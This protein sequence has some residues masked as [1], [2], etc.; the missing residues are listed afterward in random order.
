MS[1]FT[2]EGSHVMK[3]KFIGEGSYGCLYYPGVDCNGKKNKKK[4]ITKIQ[5]I[6]F[7]SKNEIIIGKLIKKINNF[8]KYYAPITKFCIISFNKLNNSN[9]ELDKCEV[10]FDD[11]FY[12]N[13]QNNKLI[14]TKYFLTYIKYINNKTLKNFF[15]DIENPSIFF[16]NYLSCFLWLLNSLIILNK[17]N[18]IHNDL[19]Y[20][21]ILYNLKIKYPMI[22]DFGLSYDLK[23]LYKL[24]KNID[25]KYIK[26]FFFD[27]RSDSYNHN[28]EKRFISFIVYN[29]HDYFYSNVESNFEKNKLTKKIIKHFLNDCV[30]S[31]TNNHEI[32]YF[33]T[34]EEIDDYKKSLYNFYMKFNNKNKYVYYSDIVQELLP[35]VFLHNDL[36]SLIIDYMYIYYLKKD[37]IENNKYLKKIVHFCIQLF[38][39]NLYPDPDFRLTLVQM[40]SIFEYLFDY[41]NNVKI[42]DMDKDDKNNIVNAFREKF[43]SFLEKNN[44]S[45]EKFFYKNFA[46]VDFNFIL[47]KDSVSFIKKNKLQL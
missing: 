18:I 12:D 38:K 34:T 42:T 19:H 20:N 26:K 16:Q 41:I 36:Y 1:S 47:N 22:I 28:I 10:L 31:I 21:N 46:V 32:Y 3:N 35:F 8:K 25:Y 5:E 23:K 14:N 37:F 29:N 27:Y 7:Y 9:L 39:K 2:E 24:N 40:K 17:N 11:F 45:S 30:T 43:E 44:I 33:F 4:T 6:N 15:I 13:N